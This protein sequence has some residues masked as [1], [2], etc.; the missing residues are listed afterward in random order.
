MTGTGQRHT[1]TVE[2][3]LVLVQVGW[4]D[5]KPLDIRGGQR[6][7]VVT[8]VFRTTHVHGQDL[9]TCRHGEAQVTSCSGKPRTADTNRKDRCQPIP[10][11]A[12]SES[13]SPSSG[14][15]YTQGKRFMVTTKRSETTHNCPTW[16]QRPV[17]LW[18]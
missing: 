5:T 4:P 2:N 1:H 8:H 13:F 14:T 16:M 11:Q 3:Y 15:A 18:L 7:A 17:A 6:R 9:Q 12:D 10:E